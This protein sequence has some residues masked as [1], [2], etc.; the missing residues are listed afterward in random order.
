[1]LHIATRAVFEAQRTNE[2]TDGE[3]IEPTERCSDALRQSRGEGGNDTTHC[4]PRPR[5]NH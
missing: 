4:R 5:P 3:V 2:R 1:M